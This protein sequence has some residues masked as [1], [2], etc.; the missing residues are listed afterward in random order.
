MRRRVPLRPEPLPGS[1]MDGFSFGGTMATKY[2]LYLCKTDKECG[3]SKRFAEELEDEELW[4]IYVESRRI[5]NVIM[6]EI[7]KRDKK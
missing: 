1:L 4:H 7:E 5:Q 6:L 3:L 2:G